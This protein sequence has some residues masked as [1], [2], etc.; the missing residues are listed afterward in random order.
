MFLICSISSPFG[1]HSGQTKLFRLMMKGSKLF[2][3]PFLR[4]NSE[5]RCPRVI[6]IL[7]FHRERSERESKSPFRD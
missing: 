1:V 4:L 3:F 2:G 7:K 5:T 6:A